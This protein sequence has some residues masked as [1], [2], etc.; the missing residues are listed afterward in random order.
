MPVTARLRQPLHQL[1][2][3]ILI[4]QHCI[5]K[6]GEDSESEQ[7]RQLFYLVIGIGISAVHCSA[8]SYNGLLS[9]VT[10]EGWSTVWVTG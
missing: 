5:G 1:S 2:S 3:T 8:A 6:E 9:Q 10:E 7:S 4:S